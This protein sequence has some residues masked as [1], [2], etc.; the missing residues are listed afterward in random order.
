MNP[1]AGAFIPKAAQQQP[2]T[3][4]ASA[5]VFVPGGGSNKPPP[6]I[7]QPQ[8][9]QAGGPGPAG[10]AVQD[11]PPPP[12]PGPPPAHSSPMGSPMGSPTGSA[13]PS[14]N[15]VHTPVGHVDPY[16][17]PESNENSRLS[18][19]AKP[20]TPGSAT[21]QAESSFPVAPDAEQEKPEE[22]E[23]PAAE[24]KVLTIDPERPPKDPL[25]PFKDSKLPVPEQPNDVPEVAPQLNG[26]W[27]LHVDEHAI[28]IG[29]NMQQAFHDPVG[30]ATVNCMENFWRLWHNVPQPSTRTPSFTYYWFRKDV[31]PN[32][33]DPRNKNGGTIN[34]TLD[35]PDVDDSFMAAVLLATGESVADA[36]C[37]NGVS[38]KIRNRFT[39]MQIWTNVST[40]PELQNIAEGLRS[41][42]EPYCSKD[43]LAKGKLDFFSHQ[44]TVKTVLTA[45]PKPKKGKPAAKPVREPDF[46]F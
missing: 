31:K 41:E 15:Q 4:R 9:A 22:E 34:I 25:E 6:L 43:N 33:E 19:G 2:T 10:Y 21:K 12:P 7:P 8:S 39:M 45:A 20:W 40:K 26:S 17:A 32:W 16:P 29:A 42:L 35:K 37:I 23:K 46:Q 13:P 24:T 18:V 3:L 44:S 11:V 30:I 38:L 36:S 5:R 1:N 28:T 14:Y 27:S